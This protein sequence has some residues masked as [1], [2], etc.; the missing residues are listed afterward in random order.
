MAP[1]ITATQTRA[2]GLSNQILEGPIKRTIRNNSNKWER[3][4]QILDKRQGD[5]SSSKRGELFWA[6]LGHAR[7][8]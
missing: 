3:D 5:P 6:E 1:G 2:L 7:W 8:P 4:S